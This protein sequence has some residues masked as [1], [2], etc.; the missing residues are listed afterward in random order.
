MTPLNFPLTVE[1]D[2]SAIAAGTEV[3]LYFDLRSFRPAAGAFTLD[4]VVLAG[5]GLP[6]L[7]LELDPASDSG[8]AGDGLT[9]HAVVDLV[10]ARDPG[11]DALLDIDGDGDVDGTDYFRFRNAYL[12]WLQ[13][14][15]ITSMFDYD[16]DGDLD[17]DDLMAFR[18]PPAAIRTRPSTMTQAAAMRTAAPFSRNHTNARTTPTTM[19]NCR[20]AT[21]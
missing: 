21:T 5:A 12:E 8:A 15:T 9:N 17:I 10:G 13:S 7:S 14:Q 1:V 18:Y 16:R 19:L 11:Q 2:I 4:A 3:T 6:P 20:N